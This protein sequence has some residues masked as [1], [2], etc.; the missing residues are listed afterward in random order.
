M[1]KRNL[2][3]PTRYLV[4]RSFLFG[5]KY[6]FLNASWRQPEMIDLG[7]PTPYTDFAGRLRSLLDSFAET[8]NLQSVLLT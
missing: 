4:G 8:Y 1:P 3:R 6:I 7:C 2:S 5:V